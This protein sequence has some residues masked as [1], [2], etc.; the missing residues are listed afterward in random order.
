GARHGRPRHGRPRHGRPR[1]GRPRH[2]RPRHGRP[3]HGAPD[4]LARRRGPRLSGQ[5]P[6]EHGA[7]VRARQQHAPT[8]ARL[9]AHALHPPAVHDPAGPR[10]LPA[11]RHRGRRVR[12][13]DHARALPLPPVP[14]RAPPGRAAEACCCVRRRAQDVQ[15][16]AARAGPP[17]RRGR[18]CPP[19]AAVLAREGRDAHAQHRRRA[20]GLGHAPGSDVA[21]P[22]GRR[23]HLDGHRPRARPAVARDPGGARPRA[24]SAHG[25][26]HEGDYVSLRHCVDFSSGHQDFWHVVVSLKLDGTG[27]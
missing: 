5:L 8:R 16:D 21:G 15:E 26:R 3:R 12:H 14:A 9:P 7:H 22:R 25:R 27:L 10:G 20:P 2:G 6:H 24:G 1:H 11:G 18:Q 4:L 17:R 13:R 19:P 23:V